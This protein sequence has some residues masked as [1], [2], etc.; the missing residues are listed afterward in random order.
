MGILINEDRLK[1]II[2]EAA[3]RIIQENLKGQMAFGTKGPIPTKPTNDLDKDFPKEVKE[4]FKLAAMGDRSARIPRHLMGEPEYLG[5]TLMWTMYQQYANA[6]NRRA[7]LGR[8]DVGFGTF[9][10]KLING[11][12]GGPM[13]YYESDGNYLF[14]LER[15]GLFVCVYFAPKSAGIG[16][17]KFVKEVCEYNNVVFSVTTDL[18]DML[19][20]L[21]CP[22]WN[23]GED[24][25]VKY[26]GHLADKKIYGSTQEAADEGAKLVQL[27]TKS[28]DI[29]NNFT[30][31][32]S[33]NP[34]LQA[35]Y[36]KDPDVV[37]KFM[38]HPVVLKFMMNNPDIIQKFL[39]DP[40]VVQQKVSDPIMALRDY[41]LK[42]RRKPASSTINEMK[43]HK[44]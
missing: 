42:Y 7:D 41:L 26:Q 3:L 39:D 19:E 31:L 13:S 23:D 28:K 33:Q 17:F 37:N 34:H 32:L 24:I 9:Y 22:K 6:M 14:G 12:L 38:T 30:D 4:R 11:W 35:L 5:N 1:F 16:M 40:S 15:A 18:A 8:H 36:D 44:K 43:K 25:K 27:M 2:E 20:R 21:G 10:K 29:N